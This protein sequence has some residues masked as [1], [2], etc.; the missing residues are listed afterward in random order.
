MC[1]I[2]GWIDFEQNLLTKSSILQEMTNALQTRGPDAENFFQSH[3]ALLGH[4]RLSVVD[5]EGGK[6]PMTRSYYGKTYTVIYNGELYNTQELKIDL[7]QEGIVFSTTSDTEVLLYSYIVW[8]EDCVKRFNGIFAF[9]VWNE[10]DQT[11]FI[12]RDRM[13]VK[14]FFFFRPNNGFVFSS[15]LKSFFH[16]PDF[17][18]TLDH[19]SLLEI[20]CLGPARRPGSGIYKDVYELQPGF[21]GR[22]SKEEFTTYPY[23]QLESHYH[24]DDLPDTLVRIRELFTDSVKRQLVSDVPLCTFL[25]GGVDSSAITAIAAKEYAQ[26]RATLHTFSV[27]FEDNQK[28]FHANPFQ[29]SQD[30]PFI[31]MIKDQFHTKHH[32]VTLSTSSVI[33][34]LEEALQARDHPGMADIDSSLLLF[35]REVKDHAVVALSGECADEIFGGY[36]WFHRADFMQIDT[37]PWAP[38]IDARTSI[39]SS[40]ILEKLH[41]LNYLTSLY[42]NNLQ[43]VPTMDCESKEETK[44]R[45]WLYL[46]MQWFM[47]T[48]LDRKDRMSMRSGL[49][50]RVPFCDHRLVEYVWNLPWH[51]KNLEGMEKGILRKALESILPQEIIYRKKNPYPKTYHPYFEDAMKAQLVSIL[52]KPS[53]PLHELYNTRELVALLNGSSNHTLP[54]FG[55][56]MNTPRLYCYLIQIHHWIEKNNLV[57]QV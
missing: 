28:Y 39:F 42:H 51:F 49:E 18:K 14:P 26:S 30:A 43:E 57:I 10:Q 37:F 19:T 13:G 36:P 5:L 6:Q 22:I 31:Q 4:R 40:Q 24:T 8:K 53:S 50:V 2:A 47:T 41:P 44:I 27:E 56:L 15:E 25:S 38:H 52:K 16:H 9:S 33:E 1:G 45:Q 55:Q 23:W 48:L 17:T 12:A 11:L 3:H 32:E 34:Y 20:L 54:W 7:Q 46:T 21:A 35:C 29:P